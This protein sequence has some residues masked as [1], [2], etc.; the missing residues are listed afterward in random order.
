MAGTYTNLLYHCV[1]STKHRRQLIKPD[2][3]EELYKYMG[4]IVRGL[5]GSCL[6]INGVEDHVHLLVKLKPY[7]SI[8][9]FHRELKQ[10]SSKWINANKKSRERFGWQDGYAAFTV[11]ESAVEDV[12]RYIQNQKEHH[13][14]MS[15]KE[16]LLY[17]LQKHGVDYDERYLW[18]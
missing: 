14:K 1:F 17:F 15:F 16:E 8:S 10:G 4:G 11:S 2:F 5:G 9:D 13:K 3:E 12:R 7:P 18:I 6:E